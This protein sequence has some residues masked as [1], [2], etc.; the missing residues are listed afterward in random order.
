VN[1]FLLLAAQNTLIALVLAC[2]VYG[3]TRVWRIPPLAHLLWLLV[4]VKLVAP[5]VMPVNLARLVPQRA[6]AHQEP[7]TDVLPAEPP[8]ARLSFEAMPEAPVVAQATR[9]VSK[10]ALP[11]TAAMPERPEETEHSTGAAGGFAWATQQTTLDLASV[12]LCYSWLAGTVLCALIAATRI[13]RFERNLKGTLAAP[14]RLTNL[15]HEIAR[16]LNLRHLPDVRLSEDVEVPL[17]WWAGRQPTIVLPQRLLQHLVDDETA[18]ILAHELAHLRRRDHWVRAIE[19]LVSVVYW[20]NPL[21]WAV[22][23]QIHRAEDVCCDAWVRWAFPESTKRYAEV[24]LKTAELINC[25]GVG[26][27]LLPAS[28]FLGSDSLKA[29]IEMI[30]Q[31]RFAPAPSK[32]SL[33]VVALFA[34]VALPSFFSAARSEVETDSKQPGSKASESRADGPAATAKTPKPDRPPGSELGLTH[35]PEFPH[36]VKFEQGATQFQNG[37]KI[38]ITEV[39]GTA[40]TFTPGNIYWIKGTYTLA[41]HAKARLLAATTASDSRFGTG[42]TFAV[43]ETTVDRGTGTFT[44]FLPMSCQGWPHVSFYPGEGGGDFG[45]AYFGTGDSVLR[46]WWSSGK[47][48]SAATLQQLRYAVNFEPGVS[49]FADGDKI[50]ITEVRGTAATIGPD[51][52]YWIKGTYTLASRDEA[53]LM[54]STTVDSTDALALQA[55]DRAVLIDSVFR[56]ASADE[57]PGAAT[58]FELRVQRSEV[59]RGTGTFELFLPVK[60]KSWPHVSFC[61]VTK[62]GKAFGSVYFGTADSVLKKWW[63]STALGANNQE[64]RRQPEQKIGI[65]ARDSLAKALML[66]GKLE[67]AAGSAGPVT[68]IDFAGSRLI[69]DEDIDML[70]VCRRVTTLG[71][72][73]TGI[74]D[75]GLEK[76]AGMPQLTTLYLDN[77]RI[78]DAGVATLKSLPEL[79]TLGLGHTRTSDAGLL[80]VRELSKL[81]HLYI[82]NTQI[83][84]A[85]VKELK[86][87]KHLTTLGLGHT[88]IGDP[89]LKTIRDFWDLRALYLDNTQITDDGMKDLADVKNLETLGLGH[90]RITDRGLMHLADLKHLRKL[91]LDNTQVTDEGVGQLKRALPNLDIVR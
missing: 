30:L 19:T 28:P 35:F 59:K 44:L 32:R 37:D 47:A 3:L 10:S 13:V 88:A 45:G 54:A 70:T 5:P 72:G 90:T 22:R 31:S 7:V 42:N 63:E 60:H 16:K 50:T 18:L 73:R 29:R 9:P 55:F 53:I 43:Q 39:H 75:A 91:Y 67:R 46:K 8:R 27:R 82:D 64:S 34:L 21:V 48:Q 85:G 12:L 40:A 87:L 36:T 71:L 2:C 38:T 17:L 51:N 56:N 65:S 15:A 4:L 24:V 79:T 49:R 1:G 6:A 14:K 58:G 61:S 86:F 81:T 52:L 23:G 83:T 68:S 80:A 77:T 41:S 57:I 25:P 78:T 20:W 62:G 76:V 11:H 66:G 26:P 84:D 74:T 33:L 89:T 69:K